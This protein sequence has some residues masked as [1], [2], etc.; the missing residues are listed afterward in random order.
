ML[1]G[2][3]P[4]DQEQGD[5]S[6]GVSRNA[7]GF[8]F[9]TILIDVIGFG[10]II[11][12]IPKLIAELSGQGMSEAARIG[13]LLMFSYALTQF[14]CAPVM[15]GLSDQYGRRP[16]LLGSMFGFGV[17]FLFQAFAPSIG[18]LFVGRILAGL[19]GSSFTT[20]SA[21]IADIS[22]PEK[23]AQ[24]FG[25]IG[26]AFGLGFIIGPMVGGLLGE[27]GSRIPFMAAAGMSLLNFLWGWFI[28][29]ESLKPENRRRFD[30][31]RANPIGTLRQLGKYP[32][33][34][35]LIASLFLLYVA[36]N[37]VQ[38]SWNFYTM[39]KF[40]WSERTIG[41]SLAFVGII[42]ALVQTVV[43]RL[44]IPKIGAK[45][46]IYLGL[47][48]QSL[49]FVLFAFATD[50]W[51]MFVFCIPYCLGGIAGPSLQ[52]LIST[53]VSANEQGELQ[54]GLTSLISVS[55][56]FGP[57][58]MTN[59]FRYFTHADA[60]VYFPGA[61]MLTGAILSFISALLAYR[62]LR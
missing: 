38:G 50:T 29:P 51:M 32:V 21:Y 24:N 53:Q 39:E 54:G 2:D 56:I 30:W 25:M 3:A 57:L 59:I 49:G 20:A 62:S 37:A 27:Y 7:L 11:P 61:A 18:W 46:G 12:V 47:G 9:V 10:I 28:L 40:K 8:I 26:A 36:S 17:D 33:I 34:V 35:G 42:S 43:V 22:T 14:L 23:R 58:L 1:Q 4:L 13:G 19:L 52:S 41:F 44:L 15:G 60:P 55:A 48:L 31:R 6:T 5:P 45:R 16:V